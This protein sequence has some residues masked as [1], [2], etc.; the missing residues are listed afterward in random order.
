MHDRKELFERIAARVLALAEEAFP[1]PITLRPSE[2]LEGEGIE[3]DS[4]SVSVCD[5]TLHWLYE[6]F[7]GAG[8]P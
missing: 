5:A 1:I 4:S 7:S 2:L 6:D 3:V 8:H